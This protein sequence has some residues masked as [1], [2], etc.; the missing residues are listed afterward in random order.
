MKRLWLILAAVCGLAGATRAE[1][2]RPAVEVR[3][4]AAAE[5]VPLVE[6]A[7]TIFGQADAGK[8]FAGILQALV[9]AEGG[10]EGIDLKRPVGAYVGI[11]DRVEDSPVVLM[12]PVADETAVLAAVTEKLG[13]DPKK[14]DGGLYTV[15]LPDVPFPVYFRFADRY[16][17]LTVRSDKGIDPTRLIAPKVYFAAKPAGVLTADVFLDRWPADVKKAIW[18]QLELQ[19]KENNAGLAASPV[20]TLFNDFLADVTV[21]MAKTVLTDGEKFSLTFDADPK[22]DDLKLAVGLSAKPGSTLAKALAGFGDRPSA[23]AGVAAAKTPLAAVGLNFRLPADTAKKVGVLADA[24]VRQAQSEAKDTDKIGLQLAADALLP[25]VKAGDVQFGV[26]ATRP[27]SDGKFGLTAAVGTTKGTEIERVVKLVALTLPKDA[28]KFVGD[29]EVGDAGKVHTL[30]FTDP[31]AVPLAGGRLWALT[32]D[33]LVAVATGESAAAVTAVPAAAKPAPM[34]ALE[35]SWAG[36]L[37]IMGSLSREQA[38][39]LVAGVFGDATPDGKDT[40]T[41]TATGGK[42]F[43]LTVTMKGKAAALLASAGKAGR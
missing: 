9:D 14:A 37:P 18:G 38:A 7:G 35:I 1:P 26:A 24:V 13:L 40:L 39:E 20:Q 36:L 32:S 28:A 4:K 17:Y 23:A 19:L 16:A 41:V 8:Q 6:Y 10:Y 33:P 3:L 12:I 42:R 25:T 29:V 43:D 2:T 30:S 21:D 34:F 5:L 22:A 27:G 11:A 15:E 31:A